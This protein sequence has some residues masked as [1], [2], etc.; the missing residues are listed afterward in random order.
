MIQGYVNNVHRAQG[1]WMG[2]DRKRVRG[3][4]W[5]TVPRWERSRKVVWV[6]GTSPFTLCC[7]DRSVGW[8][9]SAGWWEAWHLE[10]PDRNKFGEGGKGICLAYMFDIHTPF[11]PPSEN[12]YER[13]LDAEVG[14]SP[15]VTLKKPKQTKVEIWKGI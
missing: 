15:G 5:V 9:S 14:V 4:C 8:L 6:W 7:R 3:Q 12:Y 13:S 1:Q 11:S 2:G 10:K